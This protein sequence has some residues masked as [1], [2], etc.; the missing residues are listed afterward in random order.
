LPPGMTVLAFNDPVKY[1]RL[2]Q[3]DLHYDPGHLSPEGAQIF[4]KLLAQR[5]VE[6]AGKH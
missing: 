1:P 3:F 2:Y 4:T 5:F 6:V